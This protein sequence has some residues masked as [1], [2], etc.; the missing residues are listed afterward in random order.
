MRFQVSK[1]ARTVGSS[2]GM[3]RKWKGSTNPVS[4][5]WVADHSERKNK[6]TQWSGGIVT[7]VSLA[8]GLELFLGKIT[9]KLCLMFFWAEFLFYFFSRQIACIPAWCQTSYVDEDDLEL[10]CPLPAFPK[11]RDNRHTPSLEAV[12]E[13]EPRALCMIRKDSTELQ[14]FS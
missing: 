7:C 10:L 1:R 11:H 14:L 6:S 4:L 9:D 3:L 12:L 5:W 2:G 8:S 13:M